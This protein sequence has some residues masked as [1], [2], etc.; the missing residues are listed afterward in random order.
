M[1]SS[2][3]MRRS[4]YGLEPAESQS[5]AQ[6]AYEAIRES[7]VDGRFKLG[8]HIVEQQVA[9]E[10]HTSHA[11]V[12]EALRR[13]QQEG[14]VFLR[15]RRGLFVRE[16][17][18]KD[19]VDIYN[20]R[21]AVECAAA[22]LVVRDHP[23]LA[24][25]EQT[26]GQMARAAK[27]Q[28]MG[29]TVDL[30]LRVHQQLCDLSSNRYLAAAFR[31]LAGPIRMALGIDDAAYDHLDDVVSEHFPILEVLRGDD[32]DEASAVIHRHIIS[33]VEPVLA[34][35]GGDRRRLFAAPPFHESLNASNGVRRAR[36]GATRS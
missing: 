20:A 13:L 34:L 28:Q 30:E 12:R 10:L 17:S 19:F 11:P 4:R 29:R 14:L 27:D 2:M 15:P 1:V 7:I 9:D 32:G 8:Q 23:S 26:I 24:R 18:A 3:R 16:I 6:I 31:S 5:L 35:L 21:I 36:R 22:R 33:T 25:I